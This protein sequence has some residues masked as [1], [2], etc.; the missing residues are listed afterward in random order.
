MTSSQ[1][2]QP[3]ETA[4]PSETTQPL[5]LPEILT[6]NELGDLLDVSPVEVIKRLM[7]HGIMASLNDAIS[8]ETAS[9]VAVDLEVEVASSANAGG[10]VTADIDDH[11]DDDTDETLEVRPP[12]I[13]ILGHVDHGKTSL[14][15]AI[16]ES[17][18]AEG[19]FGGITQHIGAY[20]I[21]HNSLPMTFLDTPGHAAFTAMRARGAQITDIAVI[22]VAANDG[23]MPQTIEAIN[24][25]RAAEVPLIIAANKMDL[26]EADPERVK[27]ELT[28]HNVVVED[29]GGDVLFIPVSATTGDGLPA[30]LDAIML[31]AEI[32]ELKA[33]PQ[34]SAIG[35]VVE[36]E[37]DQRRG[38]IATV[39]VKTGTLR[40][41]D[42]VVAGHISGKIKAL[43]DDH[44]EPVTE[45][46][47][48]RPVRILGLES[49]PSVGERIEAA[50][51]DRQARQKAE[52]EK[53]RLESSGLR[54][55]IS[56]DTLYNEQGTSVV[57]ELL[58]ILKAD[59]EGSAEAIKGAIESFKTS[60]VKP[61]FIHVATGGVNDSDVM[62]AEASGAIILAFNV[63]SEPTALK[64]A[65]AESVEIRNY[66]IIY[67]LLESVEQ[68]LQGLYDPIY[69][70]VV[71]GLA[72]V[73]K[74]F[75]S[76]K[77]G[78][79]AG[80]YVLEGKLARNARAR[81]LREGTEIIDSEC[82]GLR[83]FQDDVREVSEGFECGVILKD[84]NSWEE[85]DK[86][87]FYH[88]ERTN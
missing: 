31:V 13:T 17:D 76:S 88:Q 43:F 54:T 39:L 7:T 23:V 3:S 48:S 52:E 41:G 20:Q 18:V 83:R 29:F 73:R 27:R 49:V 36:A 61:K 81:V 21:E 53:K 50:E 14:L 16:R 42:A 78:Q 74:V 30:L 8:F 58:L 33:N 6:V 55:G 46:G 22:V 75:R 85:N 59:V 87:E 45:G 24:H 28:E 77:V 82:E 4:Q 12:I 44:G 67:Q 86:I 34:R 69:K 19:E 60:E 65:D 35:V 51:D 47:P 38:P 37:L 70:N 84:Y 80:C 62:L 32:E 2:T 40:L 79:I 11:S 64:K 56:L 15:D 66:T 71:D 57:K 72:E 25:V 26:P 63:A 9:L 68:A 10:L 1:T 5:V